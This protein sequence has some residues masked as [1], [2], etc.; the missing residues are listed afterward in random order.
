MN[1]MRTLPQE[2]FLCREGQT[3]AFLRPY[4]KNWDNEESDSLHLEYS[5]NGKNWYSFNGNNGIWFPDYGSRQLTSPSIY[6]Q[7]D[8]SYFIAAL[9]A[10]DRSR[11]YFVET[12]DFLTF[13]GAGY[14][15][16]D[17]DFKTQ[18]KLTAFPDEENRLKVPV[19]LLENLFP[20]YGRPEP[21]ILTKAESISLK[22]AVGK[23]PELPR[24][25]SVEYSNGG[26]DRLSVDWDRIPEEAL[27]KPGKYT[28]EGKLRQTLF[29]KPL[30]Y[31]RADPYIY[32]HT[33]GK[34]YFT[35]SYTDMEHNLEGKYQYLYIIL[36]RADTLEGLADGSGA[37]EEKVIYER[38]PIN[39][40]TMS[41]HI[42]APEIHYI[43]GNW[44]VY[45]TTTISDESSWRIRPHCLE[46][47][48]ADPMT[49]KWEVKGPLVS[50]IEGDIA[51][52]DFSLDHTYLNH[53]GKD[54]I[55]WAQKTNNISDIFI[56]Q[57]SN[58][59][60][61]CT[62]AVR[63]THPEYNWEL[64]G[65]PVDEG[66]GV[67]KHGG[68]IF[69]TFSASGTDAMYCIGLLYADEDADLLNASSWTKLPYPVFQSS[70]ETGQYGLG[71]NSFTR[72]DDDSEDLII[73]HGRQEERY[74][75]EEDYQPLYDA[76]RNASVGKI[77][78][79]KN[80]MPDFS[81]P[82][83]GIVV[84]EEDLKVTAEIIVE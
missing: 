53:N 71:H 74:L 75:V 26:T 18:K 70:K 25:L 76:G 1:N 42:W 82:A 83:H 13:T 14:T 21:V 15:G 9:D 64:H 80:G 63:L 29:Q 59:W 23:E 67:I 17:W 33:D 19:S 49:G 61:L 55:L 28:V 81:V 38:K 10:K 50:S 22:T 35:A 46:C 78:W 16:A 7:A 3:L 39:N 41:P 8:G 20:V 34:Y 4:T 60:T 40:G 5:Y 66:P 36:R 62:P 84:R 27:Q 32:K 2:D 37:Y 12:W 56:A 52:T 45:Y 65:F 54:Y 44:Y 11:L 72:S 24:K 43:H 79:D 68:K 30:I 31:H 47:C 57:L 69:V 6:Q 58:P 48:D 51:F 77:Y 73:Y